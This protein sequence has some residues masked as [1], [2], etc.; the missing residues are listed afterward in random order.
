MNLDAVYC[1]H[2]FKP[3]FEVNYRSISGDEFAGAL[4]FTLLTFG[5]ALPV[6][7]VVYMVGHRQKHY[8][9]HFCKNCG[10]RS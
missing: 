3:F 4:F 8:I 5:I 6:L 7:V 9:G 10:L 1:D 2:R